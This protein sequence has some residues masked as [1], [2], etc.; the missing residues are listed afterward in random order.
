MKKPIILI[1][2]NNWHGGNESLDD[3]LDRD[4]N[5]LPFDYWNGVGSLWDCCK[6]QVGN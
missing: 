1:L 6:E 2:G 3:L 5:L 4:R